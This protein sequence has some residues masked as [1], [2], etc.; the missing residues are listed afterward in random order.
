MDGAL[1]PSMPRQVKGLM[2]GVGAPLAGGALETGINYLVFYRVLAAL[3]PNPSLQPSRAEARALPPLQ[4]VMTA[5]AAA[6]AALSL[7]LS[8]FELIKV[9]VWHGVATPELVKD[10]AVCLE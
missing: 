3:S 9:S 2:R 8:P 5:G 6:G 4:A 1:S 10:D 7:V